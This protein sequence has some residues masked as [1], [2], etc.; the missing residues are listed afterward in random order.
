MNFLQDSFASR[1]Q[2]CH[3][4][5]LGIEI[6]TGSD[7]VKRK[8]CYFKRVFLFS[9]TEPKCE[10]EAKEL[11]SSVLLCFLTAE[12]FLVSFPTCSPKLNYKKLLSR[13]NIFDTRIVPFLDVGLKSAL[14]LHYL[15]LHKFGF[16]GLSFCSSICSCLALFWIS[17]S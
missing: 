6:R 11:L 16:L 12:L 3:N 5:K 1:L 13:G 14:P 4:F 2:W 15:G 7:N 17:L 10:I 9:K 8:K